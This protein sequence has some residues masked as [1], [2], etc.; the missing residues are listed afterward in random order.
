[1]PKMDVRSE[2]PVELVWNGPAVHPEI[3]PIHDW[4]R[5]LYPMYWC[6]D[7]RELLARPLPTATHL[8]IERLDRKVV[9]EDQLNQVRSTFP[10]AR[11]ATIEGK[12]CAGSGRSGPHFPSFTRLAWTA[13]SNELEHWVRGTTRVRGTTNQS[14]G[15]KHNATE[16]LE[17]PVLIKSTCAIAVFSARPEELSWLAESIAS[18]NVAAVTCHTFQYAFAQ[19]MAG[20]MWDESAVAQLGMDRWLAIISQFSNVPRHFLLTSFPTW[21]LRDQIANLKVAMIA[22]PLNPLDLVKM[23]AE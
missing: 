7:L 19:G 22:K 4:C 14:T 5:S 15:E 20:W 16:S 17:I 8:L 10:Q 2:R 3:K 9:C 13:T 1:M 23:L 11:L 18:L 6:R 21:N 12:L